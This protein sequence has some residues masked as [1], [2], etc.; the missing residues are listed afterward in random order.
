MLIVM[1]VSGLW[2]G[3]GIHLVFCTYKSISLKEKLFKNKW[4][5]FTQINFL[6]FRAVRNLFLTDLQT[7]QYFGLVPLIV[8]SRRKGQGFQ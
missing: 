6:V 2:H 1:L 7:N 4:Q 8:Q 5:P 3:A